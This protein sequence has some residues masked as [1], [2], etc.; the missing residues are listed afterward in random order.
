MK[1]IDLFCRGRETSFIEY[2]KKQYNLSIKDPKQPMLI[3]RSKRKTAQEDDVPKLIA[4]V[5][6]L[7]NLTGLTDQMKADFRVMKDVAQFTRV[8]PN[9]RQQVK[10]YDH[11]ITPMFC[12][13]IRS[14]SIVLYYNI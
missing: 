13:T 11:T 12:Y 3:S 5:P 6:E 8:T 1:S 14:S 9:Q 4:L 2:Y 7:C 10:E